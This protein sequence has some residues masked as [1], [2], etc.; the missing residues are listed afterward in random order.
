MGLVPAQRW[1]GGSRHGAIQA[2]KGRICLYPF[3]KRNLGDMTYYPWGTRSECRAGGQ[4]SVARYS[5]STHSMYGRAADGRPA[6]H[7]K[8]P[9]NAC[10]S[11]GGDTDREL[12]PM[13]PLPSQ[14]ESR[15]LAL[16]GTL[17]SAF[18]AFLL[19]YKD[20]T[21][22]RPRSFIPRLL[23]PIPVLTSPCSPCTDSRSSLTPHFVR[24]PVCERCREIDR[25]HRST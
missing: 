19:G 22:V 23:H 25:R 14:V 1:A 20:P 8:E 18:V 15:L 24:R 7:S 17:D 16:R 13:I 12:L 9:N 4:T 11:E 3:I 5:L 2:R 6:I 10:Q 21:R